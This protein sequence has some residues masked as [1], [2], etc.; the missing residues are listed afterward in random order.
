MNMF[1]DGAK[2]RDPSTLSRRAHS[3]HIVI[4]SLGDL[5]DRVDDAVVGRS[6]P[7]DMYSNCVSVGSS[8]PKPESPVRAL[9]AAPVHDGYTDLVVEDVPIGVC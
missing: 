2:R 7:S 1:Q 8:R 9:G 3:S 6:G 4:E 5:A